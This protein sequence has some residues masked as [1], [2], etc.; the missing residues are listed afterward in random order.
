[1]AP[2]LGH[3]GDRLAGV[4]LVCQYM[5]VVRPTT[6]GDIQAVR[7]RA[8][9]T[10]PEELV[11]SWARVLTSPSS[12]AAR[13]KASF[14]LSAGDSSTTGVAC[15][16]GRLPVLTERETEGDEGV[17][18]AMAVPASRARSSAPSKSILRGV[19]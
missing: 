6:A 4:A 5:L 19:A 7:R 16:G 8:S 2:G 18:E 3:P 14:S 10:R 17:R 11:A 15:R 13:I 9:V 1:M 12:Q